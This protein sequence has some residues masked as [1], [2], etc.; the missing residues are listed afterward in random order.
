MAGVPFLDTIPAFA[1]EYP[2]ARLI[3]EFAPGAPPPVFGEDESSWTWVD[4]TEDVLQSDGRQI[5]ISPIGRS[6]WTSRPQPAG[7]TFSL[8]NTSGDYSLGPGSTYYPDIKVNIPVKVSVTLTGN[9]V[10][11]VTRFQGYTASM[12]PSFDSTGRYAITTVTAAGIMRRL[13]LRDL[14]LRSP[15]YRAFSTDT[16]STV[17]DYW[18]MEEQDGATTFANALPNRQPMTFESMDLDSYSGLSGS[19]GL[20]T[21]DASSRYAATISKSFTTGVQVD[22]HYYKES[23]PAGNTAIMRIHVGG[24]IGR[25]EIAFVGGSSTNLQVNG[26]STD[27]TL[28]VNDSGS[29][30]TLFGQPIHI[31]FRI[32]QNGANIE[33]KL[34]RYFSL[35][36]SSVTRSGS[37]AGTRGNAKL[38]DMLPD[39]DNAGLSL[40]HIIVYDDYDYVQPGNPTFGWVGDTGQERIG[41]LS[42]EENVPMIYTDTPHEDQYTFLG[43]QSTL[44]YLDLVREAV[45][46]DIG[47]LFDGL[48]PGMRYIARAERYNI[49]PTIEL[50][51]VSGE[52]MPPFQ[53]EDD[54]QGT[55]NK[56]TIARKNGGSSTYEDTD[57]PRGTSSI[58]IYEDATTLNLMYDTQT[59]DVAEWYVNLGTVDGYRYPTIFLD[60]RTIPTKSEDWLA[61]LPG[62]RLDITNADAFVSQIPEGTI[63]LLAEGWTERL[64]RFTWEADVNCSPADPWIVNQLALS[65]GDT[66]EA[67]ARLDANASTTTNSITAGATS[68]QVST[69][70]GNPLWTRR[71]DDFSFYVSVAGY[72]VFVTAISGASSPQTFTCTSF[73]ANVGAGEPVTMFTAPV[74]AL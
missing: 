28:T 60:L 13:G 56:S 7:C 62:S 35:G 39:A 14:P 34:T 59:T 55:V 23:A 20:P 6:D 51:A 50:D 47:L 44:S 38:I 5:V 36:G 32:Q 29:Y 73:P 70:S 4:I 18:P 24:T 15:M 74:L 57:G 1:A 66:D 3:V 64:S 58:G 61:M 9:D 49:D 71:T 40:G 21:F 37:T 30:T 31:S 68:F 69:T 65:A 41:G 27:G 53:P 19:E 45:D 25:W 12:K 46:A 11:K 48:S 67:V 52:I 54:D 17:V 8:I 33:W 63:R 16:G 42:Q 10:D 2:N 72:K 43:I 26:Y 22:F